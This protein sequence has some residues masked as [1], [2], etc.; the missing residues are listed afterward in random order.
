MI[1]A[2]E[3]L[4]GPTILNIKYPTAALKISGH[5]TCL[6]KDLSGEQS[7]YSE[8]R[9]ALGAA[10]KKHLVRNLAHHKTEHFIY[11]AD[12]EKYISDCSDEK[13]KE[14]R[15]KHIQEVIR[16]LENFPNFYFYITN[17]YHAF[18]FSLKIRVDSSKEKGSVF[19]T[20][21]EYDPV[22]GKMTGRLAAFGTC[23]PVVIQNFINDV[24]P[25]KQSIIDKS[26]DRNKL[27]RY[28]HNLINKGK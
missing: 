7:L 23:N 14:F 16:L 12:L 5:R 9:E 22:F 27:I 2:A 17:T 8:I 4:P 26:H 1:L 19:F 21:R 11:R 25:L 15:I 20:G 28:L 10:R 18:T 13:E 24:K 6:D 3:L